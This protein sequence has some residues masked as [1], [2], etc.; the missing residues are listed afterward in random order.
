VDEGGTGSLVP[1]LEGGEDILGGRVFH[2][3]SEQQGLM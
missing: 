1:R 3:L 2:E